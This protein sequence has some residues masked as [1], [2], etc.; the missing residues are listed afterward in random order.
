MAI[1]TSTM[2]I[3]SSP[4]NRPASA[5]IRCLKDFLLAPKLL[6]TSQLQA[7][8]LA[9]SRG[10]VNPVVET[11][12]G[13]WSATLMAAPTAVHSNPEMYA[14]RREQQVMRQYPEPLAD[15]QGR[16]ERSKSRREIEIRERVVQ[17]FRQPDFS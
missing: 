4:K 11:L 12:L 13:A 3:K 8:I 16:K 1:G 5:V 15:I 7:R 17:H 9:Q 6:L 14:G 2:P 10:Q